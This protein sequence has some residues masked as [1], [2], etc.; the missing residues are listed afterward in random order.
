MGA[1]APDD[2]EGGFSSWLRQFEGL[3]TPVAALARLAADDPHWPRGPQDDLQAFVEHLENGNAGI[4]ALGT[5]IDAWVRWTGYDHPSWPLRTAP[6]SASAPDEGR[7]PT[8]VGPCVLS[9]VRS[10]LTSRLASP[11]RGGRGA[12]GEGRSRPAQG[13]GQAGL[14]AAVGRPRGQVMA[15]CVRGRSFRRYH[16]SAATAVVP[17]RERG[18][19]A[20]RPTDRCGVVDRPLLLGSPGDGGSE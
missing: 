4:A 16:E 12:E 18:E 15:R 9:A 1:E 7:N 14:A 2:S 5:M 6:G 20:D 8:G 19:L 10:W 11:F 3:D 13:S 17:C